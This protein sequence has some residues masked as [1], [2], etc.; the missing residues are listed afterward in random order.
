MKRILCALALAATASAGWPFVPHVA[1]ETAI[2][3]YGS[4]VTT[5]VAMAVDG[6]GNAY[7]AGTTKGGDGPSH[8]FLSRIASNGNHLWIREFPNPNASVASSV[9][10]AAD[11]TVYVAGSVESEKTGWDAVLLAY[12]A[13]GERRWVYRFD[14]S[15]HDDDTAAKVAA[16]SVGGAY[17]VGR[18]RNAAGNNDA[19]VCRVRANGTLLWS[20]VYDGGGWDEAVDVTVTKS[21]R[22][23]V[24]TSSEQGGNFDVV[25]L[26]YD[27]LGLIGWKTSIGD[28]GA[29]AD[30]AVTIAQDPHGNFVVGGRSFRQDDS[31][32]DLLVAKVYA[33]GKLAW[34]RRFG[35][36]FDDLFQSLTVASS[37]A[38]YVV[39][40]FHTSRYYEGYNFA[41]LKVG[42]HG[43]LL[44]KRSTDLSYGLDDD[45]MGVAVDTKERVL[46][47]GRSR[48]WTGYGMRGGL[49]A[50][51]AD[52][53]YLYDDRWLRREPTSYEEPVTI[54]AGPNGTFY[55]L[56]MRTTEDL[57]TRG[58]LMKLVPW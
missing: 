33:T 6:S 38:I 12:S 31:L 48:T 44:W 18:S 19:F 34:T 5:P 7:V 41:T 45:A 15:A 20:Q 53:K 39:G 16:D 51:D 32:W 40:S 57:Q 46:S 23:V 21:D 54:D 13:R 24:A 14:G 27:P 26:A 55:V 10:L 29:F 3:P 9:A 35:E 28:D 17:L 47:V 22:A 2:S 43:A 56:G 30:Q 42:P 52:G 50:Y 58:Y 36:S 49:V 8:I 4:Q 11:G 25:L 37:G 1:W